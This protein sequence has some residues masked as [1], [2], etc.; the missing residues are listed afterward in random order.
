VGDR[1]RQ[2]LSPNV[3]AASRSERREN[4]LPAAAYPVTT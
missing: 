3:I 4:L 1:V 2:K